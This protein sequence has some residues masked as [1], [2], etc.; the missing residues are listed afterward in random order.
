LLYALVF[1]KPS[2]YSCL[3]LFSIVFAFPAFNPSKTKAGLVERK[4][5]KFLGGGRN[6]AYT[7]EKGH[8]VWI[9]LMA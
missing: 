9:G 3:I 8:L 1:N 7:K 6:F 5:A 2:I 4:Q